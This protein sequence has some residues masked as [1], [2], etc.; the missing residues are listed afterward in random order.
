MLKLYQLFFNNFDGNGLL[1]RAFGLS[2][3]ENGVVSSHTMLIL[4][5][6]L[7]ILWVIASYFIGS[8]NF[9]IIISKKKYNDDI[10]KYGSKNAGT[11]NMQRIYGN[12]AAILTFLGD[13]AK[14]FVCVLAA[15][16]L[17]GTNVAYLAGAFCVI[18]H[19]FPAY[20]GFKG[21]KGVATAAAVVTTL[22]P[23]VGLLLI[24]VFAILVL[25]TKYIS[26][27]SVISAL[28]YPIFLDRYYGLLC[29]FGIFDASPLTALMGICSVIIT[30]VLV[31]RHHK[32]IRNLLN[33]EE[34]KLSL[35]KKKKSGQDNTE[36]PKSLHNIDD[37]E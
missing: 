14:G 29:T 9:S 35:G 6:V 32:N 34:N 26:L 24:L 27:G 4:L 25:G 16:L 2:V 31:I 22:C 23:L 17:F 5:T 15:R 3:D 11:S 21:G 30:L 7:S 1:F 37:D 8:I 20:F 19:C 12:K 18:G 13:A 28:L 36:N 10:R 33:G